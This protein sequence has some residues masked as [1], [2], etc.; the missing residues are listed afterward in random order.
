MRN[1][2]LLGRDGEVDKL[3]EQTHQHSVLSVFGMPGVGKSLLVRTVYYKHR[4]H[5]NFEKFAWVDVS[6]PFNP[7]NFIGL[8][9][10]DLH[11]DGRAHGTEDPINE[12]RGLLREYRCLVVTDGMW[13]SENWDWIT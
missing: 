10:L 2:G 11:P 4:I 7:M 3:F 6:H 8:L 12:C 5:D 9:L 13:T 1:Y